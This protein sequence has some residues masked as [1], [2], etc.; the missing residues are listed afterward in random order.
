MKIALHRL[1][2]LFAVT[3]LASCGGGDS[4]QKITADL[5]SN[6]EKVLAA[7][8]GVTDKAS[9]D[10]AAEKIAALSGS[11]EDIKARVDKI[12]DPDEKT[13]AMLKEKFE[14]PIQDI[15]MKMTAAIMKIAQENPEAMPALQSAMEKIGDLGGLGGG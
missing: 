11:F 12:G 7:V 14:Q 13:E 10:K 3:F 8:E 1:A 2:L 9:A 6:M 4:H 5:L 15:S